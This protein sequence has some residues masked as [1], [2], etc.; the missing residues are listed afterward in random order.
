M[1]VVAPITDPTGALI[2][3]SIATLQ[4]LVSA[5]KN[6]LVEYQL[7]Q[8]L[9]ALQVQAVN[10]Y[11]VTGWVNAGSNVL[12]TYSAPSWDKV[13]QT[14][15]A[16]VAFLQNLYNVALVTPMPVGN[17]NGYGSAGW[18]TIAS[19]Y[20]QALY[21]KQI[22]LVEHLMSLPGGT[23]AAV[24]LANLTG[25]QTAPAGIAYE[26]VFNSVGFTDEWIDD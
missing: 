12:A 22:E 6:P 14:I 2:D 11:M 25:V 5:N 26:Y 13:G 21:A 3:W 16:R 8:Q 24:M 18:T 23:S 17:A 10:H 19:A 7:Q 4:A 15:T 9:N 1:A 20:A